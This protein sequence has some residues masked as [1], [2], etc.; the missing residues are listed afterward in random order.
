MKKPELIPC[1]KDMENK[2]RAGI[3]AVVTDSWGLNWVFLPFAKQR[4]G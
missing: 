1:V 4:K 2:G 3:R